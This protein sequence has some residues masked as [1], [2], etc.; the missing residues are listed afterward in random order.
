MIPIAKSFEFLDS[1][2]S[3]EFVDGV[4]DRDKYVQSLSDCMLDNRLTETV[5]N[6]V[7]VIND[8]GNQGDRIKNCYFF[9]EFLFNLDLNY[10]NNLIDVKKDFLLEV[11]QFSTL[12]N[13]LWFSMSTVN[14]PLD[15][16]LSDQTSQLESLKNDSE[17]MDVLEIPIEPVVSASSIGYDFDVFS[18]WFFS[19]EQHNEVVKFV[20]PESIVDDEFLNLLNPSF[21]DIHTNTVVHD[22]RV[23]VFLND[24]TS[25]SSSLSL[26]NQSMENF[27]SDIVDPHTLN[28][29]DVCDN[30]EDKVVSTVENLGGSDNLVEASMGIVDSFETGAL[31]RRS[32]LLLS[33]QI[34]EAGGDS[35]PFFLLRREVDE[36][37]F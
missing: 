20:E 29:N 23:Q 34:R 3:S 10:H 33:G 24:K 5:D 19:T 18:D 30:G 32:G 4:V 8:C 31:D 1:A 6:E 37:S 28:G 36:K 22:G 27:Q 7:S 35:V 11:D 12:D 16:D 17:L 15:F 2:S 14:L 21:D 9:I 26:I 25:L 13:G